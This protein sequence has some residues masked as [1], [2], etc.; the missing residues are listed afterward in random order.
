MQEVNKFKYVG[1]VISVDGGTREEVAHR[2][3]EGRK[4]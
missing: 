2:S 4:V 1:V 3:L